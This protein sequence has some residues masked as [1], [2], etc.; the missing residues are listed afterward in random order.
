MSKSH[1][2][3]ITFFIGVV[4]LGKFITN[5]TEDRNCA[6][7]LNGSLDYETQEVYN[8]EIEIMSLQGFIN[9]MFAIAQIAVNVIDINDN[10]PFFIYSEHNKY[11]A[12]VSDQSPVSTTVAHVKADDKDSGKFGKIEYSLSGNRSGEYFTIDS[13]TGIIKTKKSFK[14]INE[15][16]LPFRLTATARDNP[17]STKDFFST[18]T[19][20]IV[21]VISHLHKIVLVIEDANPEK[22]QDKV[23]VIVRIL[24]DQTGLIIGVEKLTPR[25]YINENG[26]LETDPRGTDVWLYVVDR[27]TD[28]ILERNS[29]VVMR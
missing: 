5:I 10:K 11:Y 18:D 7:Y 27:T 17:N 29:T 8:F 25:E 20:V 15:T 12:A 9:K 26:T 3:N 2:E 28:T 16:E 14:D 21:N 19:S 1:T 6:L 24:Q 23:N 4:F 22:M 13:S